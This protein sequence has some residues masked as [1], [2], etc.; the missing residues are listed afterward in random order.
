MSLLSRLAVS[1]A[2]AYGVLS[3]KSTNVSASYLVVAGGGGSGSNGGGGGA[4]GYLSSTAIL[5]TLNTY[6]ITVGA[7]GTNVVGSNSVISGTGLTTI[8]ATGGGYGATDSQG[9]GGNGGSGGGGNYNVTAGSA[10]PSGQGNNGGTG[11]S[12]GAG[13]NRGGGGPFFIHII[14]SYQRGRQLC[15]QKPGRRRSSGKVSGPRQESCGLYREDPA[16]YRA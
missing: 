13:N 2:R 10:S 6:S 7:G 14:R 4:G 15:G 11:Q 16:L 8:T 1:A 12:T 5:S 9:T 3:S